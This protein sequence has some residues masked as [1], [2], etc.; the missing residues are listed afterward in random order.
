MANICTFKY[1]IKVKLNK[2]LK[3]L[4]MYK[5]YKNF[6][7]AVAVMTLEMMCT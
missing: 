6:S 4:I 1:S 5:E 3:Y 2:H 7:K